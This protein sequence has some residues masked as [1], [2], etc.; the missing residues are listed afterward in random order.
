MAKSGHRSTRGWNAHRNFADGSCGIYAV[1]QAYLILQGVQ[2]RTAERVFTGIKTMGGPPELIRLCR[3]ATVQANEGSDPSLV[4]PT[5]AGGAASPASDRNDLATLGD[6]TA[7]ILNV[8]G[9]GRLGM[10]VVRR[11]SNASV[12]EDPWDRVRQGP[13]AHNA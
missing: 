5:G 1:L 4:V 9:G 7:E 6:R 3:E 10:R 11:A 8:G 2:P 13:C 12:G